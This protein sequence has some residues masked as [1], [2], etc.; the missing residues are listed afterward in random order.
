MLI[1]LNVGLKRQAGLLPNL[2]T[3][4]SSLFEREQGRYILIDRYTRE[5][6]ANSA[7][8]FSSFRDLR[9]FY[10]YRDQRGNVTAV[11]ELLY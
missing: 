3:V 9:E 6:N 11:Y 7:D 10:E 1:N 2:L 4:T 8:S 5:F